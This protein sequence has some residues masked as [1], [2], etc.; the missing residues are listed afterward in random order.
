MEHTSNHSVG[1]KLL[2]FIF[3]L[4]SLA[5]LSRVLQ[6]VQEW[7]FF[8]GLLPIS[9]VYL[10]LSGLIWLV[11]GLVSVILLWFNIIYAR[12]ISFINLV[13]ILLVYWLEHT[14]LMVNELS[15]INIRFSILATVAL[16]ILCIIILFFPAFQN[17]FHFRRISNGK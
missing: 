17:R 11:S 15:S 16:L 8:S 9:P 4:F 10:L 2:C 5:G 1:I 7:S 14:L 13:I 6:T 3:I 12:V